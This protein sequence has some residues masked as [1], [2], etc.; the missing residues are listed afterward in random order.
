[1]IKIGIVAPENYEEITNTLLDIFKTN[2][3]IAAVKKNTRDID[4]KLLFLEKCGIEF[5]IIIFETGLIYPVTLDIL[6]LDNAKNKSIITYSLIECISEKTVLIYNTDNGYLP[7]IEHQNA[8]DYGFSSNSSVNVSSI[9]YHKNSKSFILYIARP[10][11]N[12]FGD[13]I[14]IGEIPIMHI[15]NKDIISQLP[16]VICALICGIKVCIS[17][18]KFGIKLYSAE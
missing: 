17:K 11:L 16:A 10:V 14:S 12:I 8:I 1:M 4:N 2:H 3:I 15:N 5:A 18:I 9:E 7:K 13:E 6:I